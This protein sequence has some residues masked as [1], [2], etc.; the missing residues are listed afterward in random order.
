MKSFLCF[1]CLLCSVPVFVGQG[2]PAANDSVMR[3]MTD[4][5]QRSVSELQFKDLEKPYF[6][7]YTVVD[8]DRYRASATFGAITASDASDARILQAQVRV[9]D[10]D[11]DNSEFAGGGGGFQG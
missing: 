2:T 10:Y 5:L 4:E 6:I 3:A 8:Q 7:Q 1:L 9:G 11:F